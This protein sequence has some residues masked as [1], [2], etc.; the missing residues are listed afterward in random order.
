MT[1]NFKILIKGQGSKLYENLTLKTYQKFP[2]KSREK[3]PK[4]G[5]HKPK[6]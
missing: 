5:Y 1:Q 2:E 4:K 6:R 3:Q